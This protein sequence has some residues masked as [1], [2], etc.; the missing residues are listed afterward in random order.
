MF[1]KRWPALRIALSL[2]IAGLA[3]QLLPSRLGNERMADDIGQIGAYLLAGNMEKASAAINQGY[4]P[5]F[6]QKQQTNPHTRPAAQN[7]APKQTTDLKQTKGRGVQIKPDNNGHFFARTKINNTTLKMMV[8]TGASLVVLSFEDARRLGVHPTTADYTLPV[9]TANGQIM[10]APITLKRL[11]LAGMVE[12]DVRAAVAPKG[13]LSQSLLGMSY[14]SRLKD[15]RISKTH[16]S[17][18]Q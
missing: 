4:M 15:V 5:A 13:A 16:L 2:S 1:F 10:L 6:L 18:M 7:T 17:L 11:E 12:R 9:N 14:L 3:Y 8:D